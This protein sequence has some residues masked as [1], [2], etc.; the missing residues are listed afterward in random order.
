[1]NSLPLLYF[2]ANTVVLDDDAGFVDHV[3]VAL[4]DEVAQINSFTD[5]QKALDF[6]QLTGMNG[7]NHESWMQP[8]EEASEEYT[9]SIQVQ[10]L[11]HK[12]QDHN[13]SQVTTCAIVDYQMGHQNGLDWCQKI[14][15]PLVQK[16]LLTGVA[17][18]QVGIEALNNGWI[19][20][21]VR[22]Q[23]PKM[24]EKLLAATQ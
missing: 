18:E 2:P 22:K 9:V 13:R 7:F 3:E 21:Y 4:E 19:H 24:V 16:I 6:V 8:E 14:K 12:M 15:N 17:D 11:R 5:P 20:Q 23:D 10:N 1:M